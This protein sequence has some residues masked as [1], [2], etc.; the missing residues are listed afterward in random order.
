MQH[1]T[2]TTVTANPVWARVERVGDAVWPG[3]ALISEPGSVTSGS[4]SWRVLTL[5]APRR[6][7]VIGSARVYDGFINEG[8]DGGYYREDPEPASFSPAG[9]ASV[10]EVALEPDS[11]SPHPASIVLTPAEEPWSR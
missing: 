11:R 1:S 6:G 7:V 4:A 9:T 8:S 2:V 5:D 3:R 10:V